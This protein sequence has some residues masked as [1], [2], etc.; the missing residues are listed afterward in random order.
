MQSFMRE[1]G[2]ARHRLAA[3]SVQRTA[4]RSADRSRPDAD[5]L[6]RNRARRSAAHVDRAE[7]A[8][9]RVARPRRDAGFRLHLLGGLLP[10]LLLSGGSA[11]RVRPGESVRRSASRSMHAC[12][13]IRGSRTCATAS[14][15]RASLRVAARWIVMSGSSESPPGRVLGGEA[16]M[17][18]ETRHRR[19]VRGARVGPPAGD[20]RAIVVAALGARRSGHV[21]AAVAVAA[22]ARRASPTSTSKRAGRSFERIGVG[23]RNW[24]RCAICSTRSSRSSGTRGCSARPRSARVAGSTAMVE[25]PYSVT[26]P[27][28]SRRRLHRTGQRVDSALRRGGASGDR[29]YGG[30]RR[31]TLG[32]R[33]DRDAVASSARRRANGGCARAGDRRTRGD[34]AQLARLADVIDAGLAGKR[35]RLASGARCARRAN[36]RRVADRGGSGARRMAAGLVA[37][38]DDR[39][40]SVAAAFAVTGVPGGAPNGSHTGGHINDTWFVATD[41]GRGATCCSGSIRWCSPMRPVSRRIPRASSARISRTA[42]GLVP[43]FVTCARRRRG[44]RDDGGDVSDAGLRRRAQPRRTR[45]RAQASAAGVAFGRFQNWRWRITTRA[46]TWCRFRAS[47]NSTGSSNDSTRCSDARRRN[48]ADEPPT[49]SSGAAR[50]QRASSRNRSVHAA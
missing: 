14:A 45:V 9:R 40:L 17:W 44:R 25:R 48:G 22:V 7:L 39:L 6:G 26:T 23:A 18:A 46:R 24:L 28:E 10:R 15:G 32:Y 30:R 38:G 20:R 33:S 37:E 12:A 42:P 3:R 47:T 8:R 49:T 29:R 1:H 34:L 43:P 5:R 50:P 35:R 41:R 2:I 4:R 11:L 21:S 13:P 19:G 16:C 27:L 31:Q 36:R